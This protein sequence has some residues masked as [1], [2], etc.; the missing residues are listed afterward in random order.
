MLGMQ[1]R[2]WAPLAAAFAIVL[3]GLGVAAGIRA[4]RAVRHIN[5][6]SIGKPLLWVVLALVVF[7]AALLMLTSTWFIAPLALS[8]VLIGVLDILWWN[9]VAKMPGM[10]LAEI[11]AAMETA[12]ESPGTFFVWVWAGTA[13]AAAMAFLVAC[14][15]PR[16]AGFLTLRRI[17]VIGLLLLGCASSSHFLVGFGMGMGMALAGTFDISGGEAAVGGLALSIAGQLAWVAALFVALKPGPASQP[18]R[19]PA[20]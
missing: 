2:V 14:T 10:G 13:V 8:A 5:R 9:P 20:R 3:S 6:R 12:G 16:L 15:L 11:H 19:E 7:L 17:Y 18:V 4:V 1:G